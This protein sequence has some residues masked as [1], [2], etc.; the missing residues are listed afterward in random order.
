MRIILEIVIILTTESSMS[1][2]KKLSQTLLERKLS[3][4][5]SFRTIESHYL[6]N[7]QIDKSKEVQ[8]LIKTTG[9][10]MKKLLMVLK[11]LHSYEI[12]EIICLN[13]FSSKDYGNWLLKSL[14][15]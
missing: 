15:G 14:E 7:N 4:C 1:K 8:L 2:A 6:W 5:V 11:E 3:A 12:P 9:K 13:A 10:K